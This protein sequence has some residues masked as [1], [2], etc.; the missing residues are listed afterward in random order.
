MV[1]SSGQIYTIEGVA[2]GVLMLVTAYLV[3]STTTVLTPQDIHIIDMQ[4]QQLGTDALAMMDT[5]DQ[6]GTPEETRYSNLTTF[7]MTHNSSLFGEE[8]LNLVNKNTNAAGTNPDRLYY[9]A[10]IYYE[11][12]TKEMNTTSFGGSTYYRENAV[13]VTRWVYLPPFDNSVAKYPPDMIT[14]KNQSVLFEVL[15]WRE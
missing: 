4:L 12:V 13:K 8:F 14:D 2:A 1:N 10:S 7:V 3:V 9:T 15:L 11:N 6:Y 5:V